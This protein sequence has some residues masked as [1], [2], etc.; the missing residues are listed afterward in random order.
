M[1]KRLALIKIE[2][3]IRNISKAIK[4]SEHGERTMRD[5]AAY[6][7]APVMK[8]TG[9]RFSRLYRRGD[10]FCHRIVFALVNTVTANRIAD[11]I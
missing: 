1:Y 2:W 7:I 5:I 6:I 3:Y 9:F 4:P 11:A 8:K 10:T